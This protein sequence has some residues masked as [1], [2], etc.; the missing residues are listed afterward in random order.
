MYLAQVYN[1][2]F[3]LPPSDAIAKLER[4]GVKEDFDFTDYHFKTALQCQKKRKQE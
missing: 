3:V 4:I 2:L 1:L